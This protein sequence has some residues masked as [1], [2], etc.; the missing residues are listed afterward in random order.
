MFY[1]QLAT[2]NSIIY[3]VTKKAKRL[4]L[5][6]QASWLKELERLSYSLSQGGWYCQDCVLVTKESK[7]LGALVK[8]AL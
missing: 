1:Q 8:A 6:F 5:T 2:N 3:Y 7:T 4:P